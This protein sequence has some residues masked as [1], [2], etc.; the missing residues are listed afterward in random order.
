MT[1]EHDEGEAMG[2]EGMPTSV[3]SSVRAL[4][5][6]IVKR[7]VLVPINETLGYIAPAVNTIFAAPERELHTRIEP[8]EKKR[9]SW[10]PHITSFWLFS[11]SFIL[12]NIYIYI[13]YNW[14]DVGNF[15]SS[16]FSSLKLR[17]L[18]TFRCKKGAQ[19]LRVT[20]YLFSLS[21]LECLLISLDVLLLLGRN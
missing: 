2:L 17:S 8:S 15:V 9:S 21:I 12:V 5:D 19:V 7:S 20:Y 14:I 4:H 13:V 1:R 6:V 3:K 16:Y 18:L 10:R 11:D